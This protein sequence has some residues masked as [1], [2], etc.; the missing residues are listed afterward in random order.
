[1]G[2]TYGASRRVAASLRR[3]AH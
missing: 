3:R 2:Q 1:M